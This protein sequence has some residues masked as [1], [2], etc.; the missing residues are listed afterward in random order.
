MSLRSHNGCERLALLICDDDGACVG[1]LKTCRSY[2]LRS[3]PQVNLPWV[4]V[5]A[6]ISPRQG[7]GIEPVLACGAKPCGNAVDH[8][9]G[10]AIYLVVTGQS[11]TACVRHD[12]ADSIVSSGQ[13][14]ALGRPWTF[15]GDRART[16]TGGPGASQGRDETPPR[17][18][19]IGRLTDGGGSRSP[20]Y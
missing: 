10:W 5:K 14:G 16:A 8:L 3:V 9:S 7:S 2:G 18:A 20:P 6:L 13:K 12:H 17:T 1:G 11:S 15:H 19:N 4:Y